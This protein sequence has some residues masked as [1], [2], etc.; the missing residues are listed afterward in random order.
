MHKVGND[1][2]YLLW[3]MSS[4]ME[5]NVHTNVSPFA[6]DESQQESIMSCRVSVPA[7]IYFLPWKSSVH[8]FISTIWQAVN[9]HN[10]AGMSFPTPLSLSLKKRVVPL[11]MAWLE[12][13]NDNSTQHIAQ[14]GWKIKSIYLK[15]LSYIYKK[16]SPE[17]TTLNVS[18]DV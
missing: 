4:F 13:I 9:G 8:K 12:T 7:D 11:F 3:A 2:Q 5:S 1:D 16:K 18:K 15:M 6:Y 10:L 14:D 17:L